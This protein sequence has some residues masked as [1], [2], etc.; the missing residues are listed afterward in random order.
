MPDTSPN[1]PS[2]EPIAIIGLAVR[3]PGGIDNLDGLWD[4]LVERKSHCFPLAKDPRF[5]RRFN[6]EDFQA[7]FDGIPDGENL[8]HSNLFEET[9][10]VDRTY[11]SLSEREAAGM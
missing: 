1:I 5:K 11:F 2:F 10:G 6:Q 8:L 7:V 9:P 3:G 4:T